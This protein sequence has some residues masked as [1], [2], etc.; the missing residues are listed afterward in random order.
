[1]NRFKILQTVIVLCLCLA[2]APLSQ[3]APDRDSYLIQVVLVIAESEGKMEIRGLSENALKAM[4]DIRQFLPFKS[5][6]VLDTALIRSNEIGEGL[7]NGPQGVDYEV[8]FRFRE[9]DDRLNF[10]FQ[11]VDQGPS[12]ATRAQ[13]QKSGTMDTTLAPRPPR[14]LIE[15]TFS[16]QPG[17][18]IVVGSSKLNGGGKA[19]LVLLTA[20]P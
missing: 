12:V 2:L 20:I 14:R 5:Y 16:V 3:A 13:A 8:G 1:M 18:T 11:L 9:N 19:L 6:R 17:E 15:S 7:L 10:D 4:E